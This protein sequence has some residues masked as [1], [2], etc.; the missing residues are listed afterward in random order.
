MRQYISSLLL[1]II[2]LSASN[3]Q[4]Q[5]LIINEVMSS[6]QQ[7]LQDE[8]GETPDWIELRNNSTQDIFLGAYSIG[9]KFNPQKAWPLPLIDLQPGQYILLFASGKDIR[10]TPIYWHTLVDEGDTWRYYLPHSEP[11][12]NWKKQNF[13]DLNWATGA[14]GFGYGD[15][16]DNT[17]IASTPSIYL[18]KTFLISNKDSIATAFFHIDYDDAFVAYL[19]GVEFARGNITS[20]GDPRF[21]A[22]ADLNTHEAVMYSGGTPER[23]DLPQIRDMLVDGENTLAV[24]VINAGINSSD[25]SAIPFLTLGQK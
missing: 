17:V 15:D 7:F 8:L 23:F 2:L 10:E 22:V 12:S 24:H 1:T 3:I 19:N 9:T 20:N 13:N 14:S 21:D 18:R 5:D 25:L 6:N 16:D 4:S 11:S